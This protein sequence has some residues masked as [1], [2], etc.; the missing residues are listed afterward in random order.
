MQ[1]FGEGALVPGRLSYASIASKGADEQIN[2][3][4]HQGK[5]RY[6][7]QEA[8]SNP[9]LTLNDRW[10]RRKTFWIFGGRGGLLILS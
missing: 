5:F 3:S 4:V 1:F 8:S 9:I 10:Q 2:T 6:E 7:G